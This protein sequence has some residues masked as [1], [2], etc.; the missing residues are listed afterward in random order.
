MYWSTHDVIRRN[1]VYFQVHNNYIFIGPLAWS[2]RSKDQLTVALPGCSSLVSSAVLSDATSWPR[3]SVF[4][5]QAFRSISAGSDSGNS[6]MMLNSS[7]MR[8]FAYTLYM[9]WYSLP[10]CAEIEEVVVVGD[11]FDGL[12]AEMLWPYSSSNQPTTL[13]SNHWK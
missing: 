9:K 4:S 12:L 13:L 2:H 3:R 10:L 1:T 6:M 8:V 11:P 5:R 7:C